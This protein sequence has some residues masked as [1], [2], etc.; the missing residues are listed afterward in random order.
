MTDAVTAAGRDA[1][2]AHFGSRLRYWRRARSRT[3]AELA[4]DLDVDGSYISKLEGSRRFPNPDIAR[5]CDD[6]LDTGG[7]L[8]GLFA[9]MDR[10]V[11][12]S[13]GMAS[14]PTPLLWA[15]PPPATTPTTRRPLA[16]PHTTATLY[17]LLEAHTE[18]D[19]TMGGHQIGA[20]VEQQAQA[21]IGMHIG[22]PAPLSSDLLT[23]AAKFARLAGWIRFDS[24]DRAGSL[25]WHDCGQ[26]WA[27]AGD[28]PDLAAELLSRHAVVHAST[29]DHSGGTAIALAAQRV[30]Q[31][32]SATARFWGLTAE[33]RCR[34]VGGDAEAS[35]DRLARAEELFAG[36]STPLIAEPA[37]YDNQFLWN[38]LAGKCR[39]ELAVAGVDPEVHGAMAITYA[40]AAL[41][42]LSPT[43]VRDSALTLLRLV[44]A[45]LCVGDATSARRHLAEADA[46]ARRCTSARVHS[47]L[48]RLRELSIQH[49]DKPAADNGEPR[50]SRVI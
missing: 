35:L 24:E 7:E 4:R 37:A 46:L 22:A 30:T 25:F 26:R 50:R 5:R 17:R 23:L 13:D 38:T 49:D 36:V 40:K 18:I 42:G 12:A 28:S 20:A 32:P 14:A 31:Q 47:A 8:S 19:C 2:S 44:R 43:H 11:A 41:A 48:R 27:L 9:L 34:A 39:L 15:S 29:G 45:C 10:G 16:N 1:M 3:Q 21:I 33:A 6:L